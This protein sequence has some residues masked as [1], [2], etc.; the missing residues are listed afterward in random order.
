MAFIDRIA[1]EWSFPVELGI[2]GKVMRDQDK[3]SS[4]ANEE[5]E[6]LP[7]E[8][9]IEIKWKTLENDL[10]FIVIQITT[11]GNKRKKKASIIKILIARYNRAMI[12]RL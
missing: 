9:S 2:K 1:N 3:R 4:F 7:L 10:Q 12:G 6:R 8:D 5:T 11:Y